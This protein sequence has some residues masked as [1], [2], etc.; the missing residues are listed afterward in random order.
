MSP[1]YFIKNLSLTKEEYQH[2]CNVIGSYEL[3]PNATDKERAKEASLH[4]LV[5][6]KLGIRTS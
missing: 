1:P 6:A 4:R 2:L 5:S 3:N